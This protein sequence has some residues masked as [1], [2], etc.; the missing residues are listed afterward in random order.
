MNKKNMYFI[1]ESSHIRKNLCIWGIL[2]IFTSS[3]IPVLNLLNK[4]ILNMLSEKRQFHT[5]LYA[6]VTY[7]ILGFLSEVL[8]NINSYSGMKMYYALND[9]LLN[10]INHKISK[11]KMEIY[12]TP[13]IYNL[14]TRVSKGIEE[15]SFSGIGGIVAIISAVITLIGNLVIMFSL[16]VYIPI[17]IGFSS[18]PYIYALVK[19]AKE[20]YNLINRTNAWVRKEKYINDIATKRE[21]AKDIRFFKSVDYLIDKAENI[22]NTVFLEKK[23]LNHIVLKREIVTSIVRNLA[24]GISLFIIGYEGVKN[25]NIK[26]GDLIFVINVIQSM[27]STITAFS[28]NVASVDRFVFFIKDWKY[29][30]KLD[31]EVDNEKRVSGYRIEFDNVSFAFPKTSKKALSNINFE[32]AEKEKVAIVGKNGSGK[33]TLINLLLGIYEPN[34]GNILI[35]DTKVNEA[36]QDIRSKIVCVFQNFNKYQMSVEDNIYAGNFGE[37][38][39][40]EMGFEAEFIQELSKKEKTILG[41][42]EKKGIEL[43]GGQWQQIAIMRALARKD[44]K[45][46]I[47]DEPT[48][49]IDPSTE[50]TIYENIAKISKDKTLI[51]ISH[52]LSAVSLCD[53]IIVL[54]NGK[55]IEMGTHKGLMER[56][57][58]YYQMYS[59][60]KELYK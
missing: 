26:V 53:K 44:S 2:I 45:V 52:R 22:R 59:K 55:I 47:L 5:I 4:D 7:I 57:G 30:M 19:E 11:I 6:I 1:L 58:A 23:R 29:L 3:L 28:T 40:W 18:L 38:I 12:E 51:L 56:K 54:E 35:G 48:A 9:R 60:Q 50:N 42:L 41:Q 33:S 20:R 17:I 14:I 15:N 10:A 43:S 25:R 32:I 27:I 34:E 37:P 8:D 39:D 46:I 16:N 31:E 13:E 36:L 49:S 24:L 21:N